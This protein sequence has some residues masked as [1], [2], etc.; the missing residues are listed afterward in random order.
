MSFRK[1]S[2]FEV[3]KVDGAFLDRIGPMQMSSLSQT[4]L[5]KQLDAVLEHLVLR[6]QLVD[7][8]CRGLRLSPRLLARPSAKGEVIRLLNA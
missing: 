6:L 4:N 5:G 7:A 8:L 2:S 1:V 3:N